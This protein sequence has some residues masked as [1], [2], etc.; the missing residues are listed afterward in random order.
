MKNLG[1]ICLSLITGLISCSSADEKKSSSI[2]S[3]WY[4]KR[5]WMGGLNRQPHETINKA[6]F[7]RQYEAN[8]ALWKTAF[9]F[10]K[11]SNLVTLKPGKHLIDSDRVF[12]LVTEGTPSKDTAKADWEAHL[13]YADIH[14]VESGKEQIGLAPANSGQ[15]VVPYDESRD[16]SF[17]YTSGKLYDA[18]QS[19]FFIIFPDMAHCPQIKVQGYDSV[20][21][22]VVKVKLEQAIQ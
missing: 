16:I 14:F 18:D 6:E 21:K 12:V 17:S 1:F 4:E 5:E 2:N 10:L 22:I 13:K 8:T 7:K 9:S 20:K 3:D 15:L 19:N 11:D